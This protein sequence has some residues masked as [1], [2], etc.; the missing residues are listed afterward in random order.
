MSLP[1]NVQRS[2]GGRFNMDDPMHNDPGMFNLSWNQRLMAFGFCFV[3][4]LVLSIMGT[5]LI[6]LGNS[7]GFAVCYSIGNVVSL[8]GMGFLVGFK[9]QLKMATAPVRLV[10]FLLYIGLL[11]ATFVVA[12]AT[13]IGVLCLVFAIAQ[14][15]ALAWYSASYIPFGRKMIKSTCGACASAI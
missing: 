12:F 13:G 2:M 5:V 10:A 7:V 6:F 9:R 8:F 15:C 11:V 1:F 3:I 14:Y 4:G